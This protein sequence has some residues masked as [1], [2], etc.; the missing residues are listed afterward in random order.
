MAN[1]RHV[2]WLKEGALEWNNLRRELNFRPDLS[3]INFADLMDRKLLR[4][5]TLH[6]ID[7]KYAD[8]RHSN[9]S[10]LLIIK[11]Q[12]YR[13]DLSGAIIKN[14]LVNGSKFNHAN[15]RDALITNSEIY[16]CEF[17]GADFAGAELTASILQDT[18]ITNAKINAPQLEAAVIKSIY[19]GSFLEKTYTS[20]ITREIIDQIPE[21]DILVDSQPSIESADD[22]RND[23]S[24]S[25]PYGTNGSQPGIERADDIRTDRSYS[26]LYGT[27]R[28]P[29]KTG[30]VLEGFSGNRSNYTSYG[31]CRVNIPIGHRIGSLG[32]P[33]IRRIFKGDDRIAIDRIYE[34]DSSEF[35]G[36]VTNRL[37]RFTHPKRALIFV[38]GFNTSFEDAVLRAAQIGFDLG[39]PSGIGLFSWPSAGRFLHYSADGVASEDSKF[40][41]ADFIEGYAT[42]TNA[43][44][45]DVIAHSMGSRCLIYAVEV[46]T[47]KNSPALGKLGQ[48]ILAAA[49]V[50]Q[51]L[52][53]NMA[54]CSVSKFN[55]TTIYTSSKDNAIKASRWLHNF[56][57]VGLYPPLFVLNCADTVA[58]EK[59]DLT[60]LGHSYMAEARSLLK[61][62]FD[63]LEHGH[64]PNKRFSLEPICDSNGS[65]WRIKG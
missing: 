47:S 13:A 43:E 36:E 1:E 27:N 24:Y 60:R 21:T 25:V 2:S 22:I 30:K 38:H 16:E 34:L 39:V 10:G 19:T 28:K 32:S 4:P 46:L 31:I 29:I 44:K 64:P 7:L 57:R 65:Y 42:K 18:D 50:D 55:K 9:M 58:V 12:F 62:M 56:P 5:D 37:R 23:R 33:W 54:Q 35:W 40:A 6:N 61:D 3:G 15:L 26:V 8:L 11:S 52:M 14:S 59:V 53:R 20:I 51:S 49:D 41:L 48:L 45:I 63:I 17:R